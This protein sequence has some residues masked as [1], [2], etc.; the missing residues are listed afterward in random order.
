MKRNVLVIALVVTRC[1]ASPQQLSA[2]GSDEHTRHQEQSCVVQGEEI[3]FFVSYLKEGIGSPQVVVTTIGAPDV[4][5]DALNLQLAVQGRGIPP[6]VRADFKEKNK[7]S[8][9]IRPFVDL[10]N[11]HFISEREH[12][13]MFRTLKGWSELHKRYGK[14]AEVVFLSRVGFNR[15]RTLALFHI[16]SAIGPMAGGGN[17]SLCERKNGKWVVKSHIPTWT[18]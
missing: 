16:S 8:C 4:D 9:V 10:P 2:Q 17:L 18:T 5:V 7:S 14:K 6:D 12:N 1:I 11:L 3:K 15:D 13:L